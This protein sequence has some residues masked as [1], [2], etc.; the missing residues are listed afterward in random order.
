MPAP[1]IVKP[2]PDP[3][4]DV[5]FGGLTYFMV[6]EDP[7]VGPIIVTDGTFVPYDP[8]NVSQ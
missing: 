5:A 7:S 3:V 8:S 4:N 1:P 6:S 2:F